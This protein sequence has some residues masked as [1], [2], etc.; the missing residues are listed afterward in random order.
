MFDNL[1]A[2]G[3]D[4]LEHSVAELEKNPKYSLISFCAAVEIFLKA[5][6]LKE[7]WSLILADP[8][9]ANRSE[10][11]SG[12]FQSV[13]LDD[14]I[15]RLRRTVGV[16]INQG[17]E[18]RFDRLRKHRNK[19][20]HFFHPEAVAGK[21]IIEGVAIEQGTAWYYLHRLLTRDWKE[22]F[23]NHLDSIAH[24]HET[25][26]K[27]RGYLRTKYDIMLP[28]IQDGINRGTPFGRCPSCGVNTTKESG[29]VIG[30]VAKTIC[31]LC[32][33]EN[34]Q[35][36]TACLTCQ[37]ANIVDFDHG[38]PQKCLFCNADIEMRSTV[39]VLSE[40]SE[41]AHCENCPTSPECVVSFD[42]KWICLQCLTVYND[43]ANCMWCGSLV[44]GDVEDSYSFG[45]VAD[46]GGWM[47][48]ELGKD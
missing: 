23:V 6:L 25:M 3:L 17:A 11:S 28:G 47:A 26:Q 13:S 4:F 21:G 44:T 12:D 42:G 35:L 16:K 31:L 19:L 24:L 34:H 20:V 14:A 36:K 18:A 32:E 38:D 2:N 8:K 37:A 46:C 10:L 15:S 30:P 33:G 29:I 40:G 22:E 1:V 45:C 7:H 43:V 9:T 41:A 27:Q 5:R 48:H 39:E